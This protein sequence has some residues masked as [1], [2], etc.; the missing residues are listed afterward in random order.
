MNV[1]VGAFT[2]ALGGLLAGFVG[3]FLISPI[4][5]FLGNV[6]RDL[7]DQVLE[8]N[9]FL[10]GLVAGALILFAIIGGVYHAAILPIVLLEMEASGFS[11]LGAVDLVCLVCVSAGITL[12]NVIMPREKG[13]RAAD[14]PGFF[15]NVFFGTFVEAAY[16][17]MFGDKKVFGGAIFAGAVGGALVGLFDV[18][19]T[20]YVPTFVVPGL[21]NEK[22]VQ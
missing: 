12:A 6:I 8:L 17:D 4:A 18:K 10:A 7:I 5:A 21:T 22:P 1:L 13:G 15:V 14:F 16:P 2:G 11:F 20:A 19:S 3:M 9:S